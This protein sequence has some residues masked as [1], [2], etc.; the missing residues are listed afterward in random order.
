MTV[1]VLGLAVAAVV[2]LA[3]CG[4]GGATGVAHEATGSWRQ[5][6]ARARGE[7][8]NWW[9]YGGDDRINAYVR[10]YVKPAARRLGVTVRVVPVTDTADAVSQVVSE[11]RA[12]KSS[13]G[14]V[15]LI[16]INGENFASGK[17]A[18]L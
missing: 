2:A 15:D 7:T 10:R 5:V 18:G 12:G 6:L 8:V 17:K 11:R 14:S 3:G 4:G 13:G 1:R 16:W 9:M